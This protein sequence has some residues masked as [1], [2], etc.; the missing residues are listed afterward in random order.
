MMQ[1]IY[2]VALY[3]Q[4]GITAQTKYDPEAP[5]DECA[6][7][8]VACAT[9]QMD[10]IACASAEDNSPLDCW[11]P[12]KALLLCEVGSGCTVGREDCKECMTTNINVV[13]CQITNIDRCLEGAMI[14]D[15]SACPCQAQ[16]EEYGFCAYSQPDPEGC[17]AIPGLEEMD[18]AA[19]PMPAFVSAE[20]LRE[21]C[22]PGCPR[23]WL[24][25][26]LCDDVCMTEACRYDAG[27]CGD[28][29]SFERRDIM[30]NPDLSTVDKL[31]LLDDDCQAKLQSCRRGCGYPP[32][33]GDKSLEELPAFGIDVPY[34]V[35]QGGC[36][37]LLQAEDNDGHQCKEKLD[38]LQILDGAAPG[39]T[40]CDLCCGSCEA[41]GQTCPVPNFPEEAAA[42]CVDQCAGLYLGELPQPPLGGYGLA[43]PPDR[44][45]ERR[46]LQSVLLRLGAAG[47]MH[48][49]SALRLEVGELHGSGI[50]CLLDAGLR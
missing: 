13:D 15:M 8:C 36:P 12:V 49:H 19:T 35:E 37:G 18:Q 50:S 2:V 5:A 28:V 31:C 16:M 30:L 7:N 9:P 11:E 24:S 26:G 45:D 14:E 4:L 20:A 17:L 22:S 48:G 39:T 27:D 34:F 47:G 46:A 38:D 40:A 23:L 41:A 42:A 21:E 3:A 1:E 29:D 25:D 32:P 33:C 10:F 6:D 44:S 43:L